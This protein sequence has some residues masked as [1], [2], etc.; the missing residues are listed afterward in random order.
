[1]TRQELLLIV[2]RQARANDFQ[3]RKWFQKDDR[4]LLHQPPTMRSN[5]FPKGDVIML[6]FLLTNLPMHSGNR[7]P[8]SASWFPQQATRAAIRRAASLP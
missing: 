2:I 6:S 3:F 5:C 4:P 8:K 1:M 7:L